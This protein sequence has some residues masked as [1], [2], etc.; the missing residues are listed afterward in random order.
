MEIVMSDVSNMK[1][2]ELAGGRIAKLW[3]SDVDSLEPSAR[4]Q[5]GLM[6]QLPNLFRHLA[7]MPD[8]HFGKG[9]TVGAVMA[10]DGAVVP[11]CVGVDIGCGMAAYRTGL[12]FE[13]EAER[14]EHWRKWMDSV[15]SRLPLSATEH[16]SP[17]KSS[18]VSKR[19]CCGRS[20]LWEGG[21]TSWRSS[22]TR[23]ERSG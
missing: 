13:G 23:A 1:V 12:R 5:I 4:E 3:V 8:V 22:T 14:R 21:T 18:T 6:A 16:C 15:L 7:I 17:R 2:L 10:T 11:N 20:G 19:W 9:A